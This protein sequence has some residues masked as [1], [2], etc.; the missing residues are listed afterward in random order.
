VDPPISHRDVTTIM[1]LL[2]DI[3]DDV[4]KIW[5]LLEEDEDG[6]KEDDA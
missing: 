3:R 2:G 1:S 4:R 6:E 5:E